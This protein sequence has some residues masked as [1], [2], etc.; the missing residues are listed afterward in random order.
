MDRP[1]LVDSNVFITLLR[2][3][4]DPAQVLTKRYATTDLLTCGMVR[5]EVLRGVRVERV[6][7]R[8]TA[9]FDVM[10]NVPADNSI[11]EEALSLA[12]NLDRAG[13]VIPAT[14]ILIATSALRAGGMVL[15]Q[16]KHFHCVPSLEV[17]DFNP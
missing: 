11:W 5:L 7:E 13:H 8:L 17:L 4:Q 12:W 1:V 6:K 14:D 16:D 2:Q 10:M 15:T 9:F 3:G